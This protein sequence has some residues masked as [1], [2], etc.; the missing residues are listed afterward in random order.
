ML[1]RP[2][3]QSS[4]S[5]S[6]PEVTGGPWPSRAVADFSQRRQANGEF[7]AKTRRRRKDAKRT[8]SFTQR[9]EEDAKTANNYRLLCMYPLIHV[10]L[11]CALTFSSMRLC[12]KFRDS[13][14]RKIVSPT[15][16]WECEAP[17]EHSIDSGFDNCSRFD[18]L[19]ERGS[20][21]ESHL[22]RLGRSLAL[23]STHPVG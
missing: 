18:F 8:G 17:A 22:A 9:R 4:W 12:V 19:P 14:V 20:P 10:P 15:L 7:H 3:L 16:P 6:R 11:L 23:P 21:N 2:C 1:S 5:S 13:P